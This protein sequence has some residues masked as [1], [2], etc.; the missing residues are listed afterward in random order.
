ME[1]WN[2]YLKAH[3]GLGLNTKKVSKLYKN[4]ACV[5]ENGK[6]I[7][8]KKTPKKQKQNKRKSKTHEWQLFVR[9]NKGKGY[10]IRKLSTMYK[11]HKELK[12]NTN[13]KAYNK[14]MQEK[15]NRKIET[16][17]IALRRSLRKSAGHFLKNYRDV[18]LH[19]GGM[20]VII[21]G[22]AGPNYWGQ[23]PEK[24]FRSLTDAGYSTLIN[25][26]TTFDSSKKINFTNIDGT[27]MTGKKYV[28]FN[29]N[30]IDL[31]EK[32]Y[33]TALSTLNI[34]D[35]KLTYHHVKIRDFHNPTLAQLNT[36][37]E[38]VTK[39][40]AVIIHCGEGLG[41]TRTILTY[42]YLKSDK[43]KN[44]TYTDDNKICL[45]P[46]AYRKNHATEEFSCTDKSFYSLTE[47]RDEEKKSF[48]RFPTTDNHAASVEN[49]KQ[50][51]LL[52]CVAKSKDQVADTLN[53]CVSDYENQYLART[54][55]PPLPSTQPP[56]PKPLT[57][58]SSQLTS[59]SSPPT[60]PTSPT[61]ALTSPSSPLTSPSSRPTSPSSTPTWL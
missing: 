61:S 13:K 16:Q 36:I 5:F 51:A 53:N 4:N 29:S 46:S 27:N 32:N 30:N 38:I 42:L 17:Y 10:T 18:C 47:L 23:P 31:I 2:D 15:R 9:S 58:P 48:K 14:L 19:F 6:C 50:L 37:L 60:S 57:S 26:T 52:N 34:D 22:M 55:A 49:E 28:R 40:S 44:K 56:P 11:A 20:A 43:F 7:L 3:K 39:S 21:G 45:L 12:L 35:E 25:L 54:S 59:P 33:K 1:T 8:C 41:R 24:V